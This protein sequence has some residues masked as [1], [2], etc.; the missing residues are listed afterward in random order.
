VYITQVDR[1]LFLGFFLLFIFFVSGRDALNLGWL[2]E[3]CP[4][5]SRAT[6]SGFI[7][8]QGAV[9]GAAAAPILT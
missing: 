2:S 5:E 7:C 4:T 1:T 6:A 8:H 9:W 3:C